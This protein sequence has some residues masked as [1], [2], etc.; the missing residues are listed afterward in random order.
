VTLQV[1]D[2]SV[3]IKWFV[4][5]DAGRAEALGILDQVRDTPAR[6]AVPELFFNEMLSVLARLL[7]DDREALRVYL[8][9]IQDLGFERIGNG[10]ELLARAGDLAC[11]HGLTGYDA[12]YAASAQ[13]TGGWW[14]TADLKAHRKI[15]RLRISKAVCQP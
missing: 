4:A 5:N 14:L 9:A 11:R 8:D 1:L 3:A 13:L 2:A 10:R 12:V 6:F 15:H 7:G